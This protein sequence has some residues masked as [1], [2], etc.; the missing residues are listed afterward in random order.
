MRRLPLGIAVALFCVL[1]VSTPAVAA[2]VGSTHLNLRSSR[3][4]PRANVVVSFRQPMLSGGLPGQR[5]VEALTVTGPLE[6]GCA[7]GDDVTLRATPA[8]TLVTRA[9]RPAVLSG[10]RWCPGLHRVALT[11]AQSSGCPVGVVQRVCPE[12]VI[13]PETVATASFTV[14]AH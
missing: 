2:I 1:A 9:L 13:V 7:G 4:A 5:I 12:Y 10:H 6:S 3:V 8:H 11:I 14:T